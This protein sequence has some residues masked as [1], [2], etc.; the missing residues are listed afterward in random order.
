M[1]SEYINNTQSQYRL[2]RSNRLVL[3][4]QMLGYELL[5]IIIRCE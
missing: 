1:P 5:P 4:N 3:L 2:K